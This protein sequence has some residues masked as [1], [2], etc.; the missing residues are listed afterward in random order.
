MKP[1]F[2]EISGLNSIREKI[3]ID[4]D[5]LCSGGIFGIFG[6][7]GS[8]KSSIVDAITLALYGEVERSGKGTQGI[9]NDCEK[10]LTVEFTFALGCEA[11]KRTFRVS[12]TYERAEKDK[13]SKKIKEE[14]FGVRF[15]KGSIAELVAGEYQV[16]ADRERDITGKVEEL[17]GLEIDDFTRAVVL[18]QGKFAEFLML[19]GRDRI[20]MLERIFSLAEYGEKLNR[21]LK[22][23]VDLTQGELDKIK[24]YQQGLQ[25]SREILEENEEK[26]RLAVE[27]NTRCEEHLKKTGEKFEEARKIWETQERLREAEG[28]TRVIR[29]R[30][31][32]IHAVDAELARAMHAEALRDK[33]SEVG[34]LG[35]RLK[36]HEEEA[37]ECRQAL[38]NARSLLRS[39]EGKLL[40]AKS[41][42]E[43]R[44]PLILG[45]LGP[46]KDAILQKQE[47]DRDREALVS[48]MDV[49]KQ[50]AGKRSGVDREVNAS[51]ERLEELE[52]KHG[53][54][55]SARDECIVD[56]QFR[57]KINDLVPL[58]TSHEK[59][60]KEIRNKRSGH[61]TCTKALGNL[62]TALDGIT[63]QTGAM[64]K[65]LLEKEE[66]YDTLRNKPP[67]AD[68][69]LLAQ[70]SRIEGM[71]H[72][73]GEI[74]R[75]E[76]E[77]AEL[78]TR[79]GRAMEG[80]AKCGNELREIIAMEEAKACELRDSEGSI[81]SL[82]EALTGIQ[83]G[84]AAAMLAEL[85]APGKACPVCG[86]T[87]H[88]TP[89][90]YPPGEGA[91]GIEESIAIERTR[92]ESIE[93]EL[94]NIRNRR[95]KCESELEH[96][97]KLIA[98][99]S[100][101]RSSKTEELQEK[102]EE[103][104]EG[105]REEKPGELNE[106]A[107]VLERAHRDAARETAQWK[108]LC[109]RE[110]AAI[111]ILRKALE[112]E[113]EKKG[114]K[115]R[116]LASAESALNGIV[117]ALGH[118]EPELETLGKEIDE[119]RGDVESGKIMSLKDDIESKDAAFKENSDRIARLE[120][121]IKKWRKITD[122]KSAES[123]DLEAS[124]RVQKEKIR[125]LTEGIRNREDRLNG[126]TG[127]EDPVKL[128]S[129]AE[130]ELKRIRENLGHAEGQLKLATAG[131]GEAEVKNGSAGKI[132]D[133]LK[134]SL[135]RKSRDLSGELD[136][137]GFTTIFEARDALRDSEWRKIA[138]T[139]SREFRE[140]LQIALNKGRE[141]RELLSGRAIEEAEWKDLQSEVTQAE[142]MLKA[143]VEGLGSAKHKLETARE[144]YRIWI[145][146]EEERKELESL[147][148]NLQV[149][150]KTFKG[151]AFVEYL[152]E[153][154]LRNIA[155]DASVRLGNL[156]RQ[157]YALEVSSE[158]TFIIRDNGNGGV[159]RPVNTLSGGEIFITSLSLALSLSSHIQLKGKYMLEFFF[160]DEGF[161]T[162]D[163]E[164]LEIVMSALE[165]LNMEKMH[166]GI[167]SHVPELRTRIGR[168]LLVIPA[169]PGGAGSSVRLETG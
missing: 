32:E 141:L 65:S 15:K 26:L 77:L 11:E 157:R 113:N 60:S 72:L 129:D 38:E 90:V 6:P 54:L 53:F 114:R 55:V 2:L 42:K 97:E 144:N 50:I 132:L 48:L 120:D 148:D 75:L 29:L 116:E 125:S 93:G 91:A 43:Q 166:V 18:P 138:E 167:I 158:G 46:L 44:E 154:H 34:D 47:L 151:K 142:A 123:K 169:D 17:T 70:A 104:P 13:K 168:R 68:E 79:E 156:T 100:G 146:K 164:L 110:E 61:E 163:P 165:R 41:S 23:K 22:E 81:K 71:K 145:E 155:C 39:A 159:R 111:S 121:E 140:S 117:E 7:T 134:A 4:F 152:A 112:G 78:S 59:L 105:K 88:P 137:R 99:I 51:R 45:M 57:K 64:A 130:S 21:R 85:L 86:S 101:Q 10:R 56:P 80:K 153:E 147:Y 139:A 1:I 96:D 63:G 106:F 49:E 20:P 149:L 9:V 119:K 12:R 124:L 92:R 33:I 35:D 66:S 52:K 118:M 14:D 37:A 143:A 25:I 69:E 103:L 31:D 40:A 73:V 62:R 24:S 74:E 30:E 108:E 115:E 94:L 36:R 122:D 162:L 131:A 8:G 82:G 127:G 87:E 98:E 136:R 16:L 160:L 95:A 3:S 133:E 19:K 5:E 76:R 27:E 109:K 126:I 150:M 28:E 128:S 89:A 67:Y 84:S 161:G 58:I 107:K 83:R 135:E 102:R